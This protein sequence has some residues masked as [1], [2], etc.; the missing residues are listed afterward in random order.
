MV[1]MVIFAKLKKNID[2]SRNE[3]IKISSYLCVVELGHN[4]PNEIYN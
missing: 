1:S 4:H 3:N 2:I